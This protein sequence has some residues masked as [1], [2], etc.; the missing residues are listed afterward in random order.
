MFVLPQPNKRPRS[1]LY[2]VH[3]Q[4]SRE[5]MWFFDFKT[6]MRAKNGIRMYER[7]GHGDDGG[8]NGII[9]DNDR[10]ELCVL[11]G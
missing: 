6:K 10:I 5:K 8:S 1:S 11:N 4:W 9:S 7:G 2:I 3:T